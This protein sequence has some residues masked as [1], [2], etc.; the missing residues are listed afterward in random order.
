MEKVVFLLFPH[1]NKYDEKVTVE[2]FNDSLGHPE[3]TTERGHPGATAGGSNEK[4]R[5][6]WPGPDY[7]NEGAYLLRV[8]DRAI[9][10]IK[11]SSYVKGGVVSR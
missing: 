9:S 5:C 7:D 8:S 1:P 10:K 2:G 11:R 6:V 4:F 3:V